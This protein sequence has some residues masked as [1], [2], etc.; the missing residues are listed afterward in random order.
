MK[1]SLLKTLFS[2]ILFKDGNA[3]S[4]L[5]EKEAKMWEISNEK[6]RIIRKFHDALKNIDSLAERLWERE[7]EFLGSGRAITKIDG[8]FE[9]DL[10]AKLIA[11]NV[12]PDDFVEIPHGAE[13]EIYDLSK[14]EYRGN[15][16]FQNKLP[17]KYRENM[18][19]LYDD[20]DENA[21]KPII[22]RD[23]REVTKEGAELSES[24]I[25]WLY[26]SYRWPSNKKKDGYIV[27]LFDGERL[28]YVKGY[29][30][31]PSIGDYFPGINGT[32]KEIFGHYSMSDHVK[33][34]VT[35]GILKFSDPAIQTKLDK[36]LEP[37]KTSNM[38]E[39]IEESVQK[40]R[41]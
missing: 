15:L 1:K 34:A 18:N 39:L 30:G 25:E 6:I 35:N 27:E 3:I 36:M 17:E 11:E 9:K 29:E 19:S 26:A 28:F 22:L 38:Q 4:N 8:V 13:I 23:P 37:K 21:A 2:R 10:I 12:N 33:S 20:M 24:P 16:L 14:L 5:E 7:E 41:N 32:R 31:Q 40:S